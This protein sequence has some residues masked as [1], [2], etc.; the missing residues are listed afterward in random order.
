MAPLVYLLCFV[1]SACCSWLLVRAYLRSRTGVLLWTAIAFVVLALNNFIVV[2]DLVL[3]PAALDLR[4]LRYATSLVGI[5]TLLYGFIW[6]L[7]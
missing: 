6:E 4:A 7:D 2:V 3:T 5:G 1:A